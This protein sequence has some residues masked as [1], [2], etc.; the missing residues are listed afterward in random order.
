MP[1]QLTKNT[2]MAFAVLDWLS[3]TQNIDLE[4]ANIALFIDHVKQ[5]ALAVTLAVPLM[6]S[7]ATLTL[8]GPK[9]EKRM[10]YSACVS[11]DII[12]CAMGK[13]EW[14]GREHVSDYSRQRIVI[15]ITGDVSLKAQESI[16]KNGG[17]Y[18][19]PQMVDSL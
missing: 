9:S 2:L 3:H 11:A 18:L 5:G 6:E 13:P 10:A 15:D 12:I 16:V 19:S 8:L 1:R 17:T 7:G 4:G 14:I